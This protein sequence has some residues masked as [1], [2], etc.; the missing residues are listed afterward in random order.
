MVL[1]KVANTRGVLLRGARDRPDSPHAE[2]LRHTA[3]HLLPALE[4]VQQAT[5]L[6]RLRGLEGDAAHEYFATFNGLI[7]NPSESFVFHGRSRRPPQDS[8]NALLSFLYVMLTQDARA[9]CEA[10]GL[11]PAVGFLHTDRPGRPSLALDLIE[12]FRAFIA[13]R[14][15]LTVIN[16]QQVRSEGFTRD[17]AGGV[18]MGDDTRKTVLTAY[19]QRKQETLMHPFLGEETTVG[20]LMHLQARLLAR[21]LRGELNTYPAFIA[22]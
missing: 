15:A 18:T 10:A 7:T 6:D 2:S 11:D 17:E 3:A 1:A 14:V 13:D 16:R 5:S 9:A 19:Q 21:Y 12:E 22:R 20:L 8:V 4:A